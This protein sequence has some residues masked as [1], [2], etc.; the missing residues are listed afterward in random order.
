[1]NSKITPEIKI[2]D[3]ANINIQFI[4]ILISGSLPF[5]VFDFAFFAIKRIRIPVNPP[6]ITPPI[7]NIEAK[8]IK[9]N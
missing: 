4:G 3:R 6:E 8:P 7:P 9:L 5:R 2:K 1:M